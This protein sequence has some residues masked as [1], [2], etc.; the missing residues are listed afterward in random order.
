[1]STEQPSQTVEITDP[2]LALLGKLALARLQALPEVQQELSPAVQQTL[3]N[4]QVLLNHHQTPK[5]DQPAPQE[6]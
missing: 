4:L 5:E 2:K 1:M 6:E 3:I